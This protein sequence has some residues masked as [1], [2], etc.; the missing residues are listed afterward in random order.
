M[1]ED[2]D[3]AG[4]ALEDARERMHKAIGAL[5]RELQTLRTGRAH[6][7]LVEHVKVAYQG[8]VLPMNQVATITA[9]DARMLVVQP[10][11]KNAIQP[12]TKAIQQSDLG[13]NPQHDGSLIRLIVPELT[14]ERRKSLARRVSQ[15]TE[16]A[17]IAVRN[18]RRAVL[19]ELR[20]LERAKDLSQD[21]EHRAQEA[22]EQITQ[23]A[24]GEAERVSHEKEREVLEA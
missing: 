16:D 15:K 22:L 1:T 24:I 2:E 5:Q 17:R 6:P 14:E 21:E 4:L 13:L 20:K 10:W 3:L 8:A 9:P 7:A 23:A 19:D 18:V 12:I 11:D